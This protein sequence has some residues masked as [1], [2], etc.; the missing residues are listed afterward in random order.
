MGGHNV[1]SR[2]PVERSIAR[3]GCK[4]SV[5]VRDVAAHAGVSVG[6]VSNVMNRPGTVSEEL[7][8]RVTSSIEQ[9]GYSL[10]AAARQLRAGRS[11]NIGL[12]AL[13]LRN[14]FFADVASGAERGALAAGLTLVMGNSDS[15]EQRQNAYL[16]LFESQRARGILIWPTPRSENRL[17]RVRERGISVV[18]L[19][20]EDTTGGISSVSMDN[21][22]GGAIAV[23]HLISCG[24]TRLAFVGD[25]FHSSA[26]RD[27]LLGARR[28]VNVHRGVTMHVMN[29]PEM[30]ARAGRDAGKAIAATRR[31]DRPDAVFV[32]NDFVALGLIAALTAPGSHIAVPDD[33]A[34][35]GYDDVG[36]A[37]YG[38]VPLSSVRQ[39]SHLIGLTAM[40]ILLAECADPGLAPRTVQFR[41][42]LVT[43]ASTKRSGGA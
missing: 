28:S 24:R 31:S 19:D 10:N 43:R 21:V 33:I 1:Q 2:A 40:D 8:N 11:T 37:R 32:A 3:T 12:I 25:H 14:P 5:R 18:L 15:A 42:E 35:I 27:R 38:S 7:R 22:A 20:K 4:M 30:S 36:F 29:I 17:R 9:L 41:P 16:D 6:S 39:P 34:V 13:D 26:I 23:E